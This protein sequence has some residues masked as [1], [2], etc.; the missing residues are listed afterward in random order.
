M[1]AFEKLKTIGWVL[2]LVFCVFLILRL[3]NKSE[4]ILKEGE[5]TIATVI[6][7]KNSYVHYT[8]VVD[9]VEYNGSDKPD[10][11]VYRSIVAG[12]EYVAKYHRDNP[13][14]PIV[15]FSKPVIGEGEFSDVEGI[16]TEGR[17]RYV[18]FK[19]SVNNQWYSRWQKLE[20]D[21]S[22]DPK[23]LINKK[24]RV[25]YN[26]NTPT[27]AYLIIDSPLVVVGQKDNF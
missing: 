15:L 20:K 3:R 9:N 12:E 23:P 1:D 21:K 5:E 26:I 11:S 24:F 19:Y 18:E 17:G 7:K 13:R 4:K 14:Y 25:K 8:Y 27:I 10:F 6:R 2:I 22:F 16:L